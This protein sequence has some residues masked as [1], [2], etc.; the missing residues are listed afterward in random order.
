MTSVSIPAGPATVRSWTPSDLESLVRNANSRNVWKNLRDAFPHP[1]E[2]GD[3]LRW[4]EAV[5]TA[6]TET[7]F[8]IDVEGAAVGGI[9]LF[10][11]TDIY[12]GSAEMGYWLGERY[13]NRW[14]MT[15]VV[16]AFVPFVIEQFDLRRIYANVFDFNRPSARILEKA[17]FQLEGRGREAVL[18]DGV[19]LDQLTYALV[20]SDLTPRPP[21]GP[22]HP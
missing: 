22:I 18:K 19:V 21:D 8:A 16:A 14:I 7:Q 10:L 13:W 1:Y 4:L 11:Q 5:R 6:R 9:G 15:A 17:G 2:R 3:G 12:R 20:R